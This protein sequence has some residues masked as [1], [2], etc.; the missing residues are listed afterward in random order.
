MGYFILPDP[1]AGV[2]DEL[3][4]ALSNIELYLKNVD[5]DY[6][7]LISSFAA[8]NIKRAIQLIKEEQSN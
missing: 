2:L 6:D 4:T 1:D 7:Y 8:G 5:N 3:E